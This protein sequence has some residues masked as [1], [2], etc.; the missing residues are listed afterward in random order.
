MTKQIEI[1]GSSRSYLFD[2]FVHYFITGFANPRTEKE[3]RI[4]LVAFYNTNFFR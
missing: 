3:A 1:Y 4:I 2:C